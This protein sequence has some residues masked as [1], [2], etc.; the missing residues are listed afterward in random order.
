MATFV[1]WIVYLLLFFSD[2][3]VNTKKGY[4]V[5]LSLGACMNVCFVK[6]PLG[7]VSCLVDLFYICELTESNPHHH[8]VFLCAYEFY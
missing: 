2:L 8:D 4:L 1:L 3:L 5:V 7:C 6:P